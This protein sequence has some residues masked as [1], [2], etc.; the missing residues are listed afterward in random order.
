MPT[1][2]INE[3]SMH[4][5]FFSS[6][7]KVQILGGGFGNGKTAAACIK[8]LN[9]SK[10]YP[11][12]N[13][14]IARSTYPKLNDTIRKEFF[15]WCPSD[16]IKRFPTK[17]DNTCI[18]TNG[19]TINFRY[20]QQRGKQGVDGQTS[21]NLLS[22]TYDWIVVDQMEDP[23]I[24]YKDFLDLMGRLRGSA[25][26]RGNDPTMP[27]TGPRWMI[28]TVNPSAN[29]FYTKL[30]KPFQ[31]F[32]RTQQVTEDLLCDVDT[33]VPIMDIFEGST[34]ENK[35]NLAPDFIRGLEA[36]YKGQMRD[37]YLMGKW[38]AFEGL[39]YPD[40]DRDIHRIPQRHIQE[41]LRFVSDQRLR[42]FALEGFD[43]GMVVPSCYLLACVDFTGRIF[44]IDGFYKAHMSIKKIAEE[45]L[46][47]RDKYGY[48]LE[49]ENPIWCDP[50]IFKKTV[51]D[52][53]GKGT[54]TVARLITANSDLPLTRGQNDVVSGITKVNSYMQLYDGMH[55]E[56]A[57][58]PGPLI[59]FS[60]HLQFIEDEFM[61]YFWDSN[62]M[63]DRVDKPKDGQDHAMDTI[64][65][66]VSKIPDASEILIQTPPELKP[67][68]FWQEVA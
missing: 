62:T 21:S 41:M 55:Y 4:D 59:Y 10:D 58:Q 39:V 68:M 45:I 33:G 23:E 65:Y 35:D 54:D 9:L 2:N 36:S 38:G 32:K 20:I 64:K 61:A 1:Y 6:R 12:S 56:D 47:L 22:A 66:M 7:I 63:G 46:T 29:W 13:G 53:T 17:D 27:I 14:L 19:T 57:S 37:R 60:D 16:A 18:L 26:Y 40:Y 52:G 44:I 15:H 42:F 51:V 30:V 34:Y 11:G 43:F 50:A 28:M 3:G 5:R 49:F 24:R 67:Y 8:A 48:A 31:L 25:P